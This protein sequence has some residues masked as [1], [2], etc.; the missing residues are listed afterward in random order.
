[1]EEKVACLEC[2]TLILIDTA[3]KNNGLCVPCAKG[4]RK[5]I[6]ESKKRYQDDKK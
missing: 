4:Y 5:Q 2:N 3:T 1:M 6:E